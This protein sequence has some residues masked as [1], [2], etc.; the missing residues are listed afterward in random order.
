MDKCE[1]CETCDKSDECYGVSQELKDAVIK[2]V[3]ETARNLG[4]LDPKVRGSVL[5][6]LMTRHAV[7]VMVEMD[8]DPVNILSQ[9]TMAITQGASHLYHDEKEAGRHATRH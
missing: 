3:D 5:L 1:N 2:A 8:A 6:T 4:K 7:E 9:I